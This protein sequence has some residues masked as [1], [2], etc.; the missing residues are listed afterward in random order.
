[1]RAIYYPLLDFET[2]VNLIKL[3]EKR[4]CIE[5]DFFHHLINVVRIRKD[6]KI[7]ILSGL[8]T[9]ADCTFKSHHNGQINLEI[10]ELK[11]FER[12]FN[13]DL[14]LS[15][16]KKEYF[17]EC[18]AMATQI[19]INKIYPFISQFSCNNYQFTKRSEN[20]LVS[21][22]EQSN[23]PF[24]P[25]INEIK[26]FDDLFKTSQTLFNQYDKVFY[27]TLEEKFVDKNFFNKD[28]I[29][30]FKSQENS[31]LAFIL[32][33]E[34]GLSLNEENILLNWNN[35]SGVSL[36]CPILKTST[37]ISCGYG[38]VMGVFNLTQNF[39]E[40]EKF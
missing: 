12:K 30:K 2:W 37:A 38:Y 36:P 29:E 22:L 5:G 1:M 14:F 15:I 13:V 25:E 20:I 7:R 19:G 8:G 33:A 27:F 11:V 39:R 35:V 40:I 21:N 26:K 28:H 16:P 18:L 23:N 9:Y 24:K 10:N 4:I 3:G 34:G 6:E 32:G 17:E 31:K